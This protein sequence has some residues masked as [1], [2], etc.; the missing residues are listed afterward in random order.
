MT[1]AQKIWIII[2]YITAILS[3]ITLSIKSETTNSISSPST[4][5]HS[6]LK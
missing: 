4:G 3:G 1:T 2:A 6:E 5:K